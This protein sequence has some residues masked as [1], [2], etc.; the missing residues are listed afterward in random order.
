MLI[1]Y[2]VL[3]NTSQGSKVWLFERLLKLEF[4]V[5]YLPVR[6][7]VGYAYKFTAMISEGIYYIHVDIYIYV[8]VCVCACVQLYTHTHTHARTHTDICIYIHDIILYIYPMYIN[9]YTKYIYMY[10]YL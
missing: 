2:N 5:P 9:T 7:R 1:V 6:P 4:K 10:R 3:V 8:C